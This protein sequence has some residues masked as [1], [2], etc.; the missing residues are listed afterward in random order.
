MRGAT[1]RA[2]RTPVAAPTTASRA[3]SLAISSAT[4][5]GV[6]PATWSRVSSLASLTSRD[7]SRVTIN[8]TVT[9]SSSAAK[10]SMTCANESILV[11][12]ALSRM[13]AAV[14][15][16][17]PA[18]VQLPGG[19]GPS[20][21]RRATTASACDGSRSR[22]PIDHR[23]TPTGSIASNSVVP[24][25]MLPGVRKVIGTSIGWSRDDAATWSVWPGEPIPE[26]VV[27]DCLE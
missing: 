16:H 17:Q 23:G 27:R 12:K 8:S 7:P 1:R 22:S 20:R 3:C 15:A 5:A 4:R 26:L 18:A 14:L 11:G 24:A 13:S 6:A 10:N 25:K 19:T 9:I 2:T 21:L